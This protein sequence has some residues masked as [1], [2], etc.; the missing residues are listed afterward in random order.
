[1][2]ICGEGRLYTL[3]NQLR[4]LHS[5]KWCEDSVFCCQ[6]LVRHIFGCSLTHYVVF[7]V[8]LHFVQSIVTFWQHKAVCLTIH[9]F[10][11]ESSSNQE[12]VFV[13][14]LTYT[15]W[16]V[17]KLQLYASVLL[18]ADTLILLSCSVVVSD[19]LAI[20]YTIDSISFAKLDFAFLFEVMELP[21]DEGIIIRVS[22]SGDE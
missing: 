6:F 1:M 2:L 22:L 16:V 18:R 3:S 13:F 15:F 8:T 4:P 21:A 19:W 5:G 17:K 10:R 20:L 11:A 7:V 9:C 14:L 12:H